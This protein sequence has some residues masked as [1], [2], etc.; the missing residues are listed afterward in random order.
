MALAVTREKNKL[1]LLYLSNGKTWSGPVRCPD[2]SLI[3]LKDCA[4]SRPAYD[5]YP[6]SYSSSSPISAL[7]SSRETLLPLSSFLFAVSFKVSLYA[8]SLAFC[9]IFSD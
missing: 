6:R 1:S 2:D 8:F 5:C 9:E 3:A 7:S 4:E